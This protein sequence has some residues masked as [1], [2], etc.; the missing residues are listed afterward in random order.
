M[1]TWTTRDNR[2]LNV[3]DMELGHIIN[4]LKM[5]LRQFNKLRYEIYS[6]VEDFVD[7]FGFDGDMACAV[8]L[9]RHETEALD[10]Y[11]T[12]IT[13]FVEELKRRGHNPTDNGTLEL[14]QN[15]IIIRTINLF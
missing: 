1:N 8:G 10:K 3:A 7:D 4:C 13:M 15:N 14:K 6:Q 12:D 5:R 11:D 9:C 2:T